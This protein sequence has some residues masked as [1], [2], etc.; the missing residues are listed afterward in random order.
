[1]MTEE[2]FAEL[3]KYGCSWCQSD[4]DY[5][6][7]GVTIYERDD[8]LLCPACSNAMIAKKSRRSF[9]GIRQK[10]EWTRSDVL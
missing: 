8:I 4:V 5:H 7:V 6:D 10:H 2:K 1:M 9:A 3:A